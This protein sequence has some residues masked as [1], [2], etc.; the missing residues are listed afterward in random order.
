ME[1]SLTEDDWSLIRQSLRATIRHRQT[2]DDYLDDD[3]FR[4]AQVEAAEE[5][6]RC[7]EALRSQLQEGP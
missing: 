7:V 3:R 5:T 4:K 6:L 2:T 1:I